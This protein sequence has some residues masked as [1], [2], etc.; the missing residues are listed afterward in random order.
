MT[1]PD[2]AAERRL[3]PAQCE[4]LRQ[5]Y[6]AFEQAQTQLND[7]VT[8]LMVEHGLANADGWQLT[9]DFTRFVRAPAQAD[10]ASETRQEPA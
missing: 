6:L 8:Y 4:H 10:P 9:A 2:P 7:F 3:T 1:A 5:L